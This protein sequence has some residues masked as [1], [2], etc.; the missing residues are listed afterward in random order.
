MLNSKQGLVVNLK[1]L[2]QKHVF[3]HHLLMNF[4]ITFKDIFLEKLRVLVS[5]STL[6]PSLGSATLVPFCYVHSTIS[7]SAEEY[8]LG[9][10]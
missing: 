9:S 1:E 2:K 8:V 6:D 5:S 7:L 4:L 10:L 3:M